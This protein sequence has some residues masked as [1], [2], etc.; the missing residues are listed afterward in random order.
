MSDYSF[1]N[2]YL[3]SGV[4]ATTLDTLSSIKSIQFEFAAMQMV[5]ALESRN[6]A[7]EVIKTIRAN[8]ESSKAC[9][10]F[11]Q[12]VAKFTSTSDDEGTQTARA[13][14]LKQLKET[15]VSLG[16]GDFDV[17]KDDVT[18]VTYDQ[19]RALMSA[20]QSKQ[21]AYGSSTQTDMIYAQD[22]I[23]KY[24]SYTQGASTAISSAISVMQNLARG[25]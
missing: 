1:Y 20:I 23:G 16:F 25:Q 12:K 9:S 22:Y 21:E 6:K 14:A 11:S 24:N 8:Q 18:K 13:N 2:N 17:F 15:A 10:E 7:E 19:Q 5:L 4:G 3:S